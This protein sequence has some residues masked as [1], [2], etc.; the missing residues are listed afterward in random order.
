[1][2]KIYVKQ[3]SL[4]QETRYLWANVVVGLV[5]SVLLLRAWYVQIYRGETYQEISERNRIRRIEIPVPRGI[6]YDRHGEVI[7]GNRP[8]FDL[9]YIPQYVKDRESTFQILSRLLHVPVTQFERRYRM[10]RGNPKFLPINLKRN[11]EQHEVSTI[12]NHKLFLPGI[13]IKVSPRRDYKPNSPV[14]LL[15]YL[16][17][18]DNDA[19]REYNKEDSANP[20]LPGDLIGQ[21]GLEKVWESYLR[22]RRGYRLIQVDAY[23]RQASGTEGTKWNFPVV[24]AIRGSDLELTIDARLQNVVQQA[25]NGKFGA[26]I[27]VNP[28]TGEVLAEVSEPNFDPE[29]MQGG[30]T[31]EEWQSLISH[32]FKPFLDKTTGGEF[33][34]GSIYKPII[35]MA[36]LEEGIIDPSKTV[37]C[38]GHFFLG[39][40]PFYCHQRSGHGWVDLRKALMKSCDVYFYQIGMELGVNKIA[41]YARAFGLGEK[42]GVRLNSESSG[43]VPDSAW[44]QVTKRFPWTTGDTLNISIGQGDNLLTPM[45]MVSLYA[46]IANGGNVWR[47]YFVKRIT[48][49]IGEVQV[50]HHPE[51]VRKADIIKPE[52]YALIRRILQDVVMDEDG[53]GHKAHVEGFTVG[54]KTG[55]VQVVS[56]KKN[57]NQSDV[58]SKWREHAIF[59]AFSPVEKAEIA[60]VVLSQND[61]V[62]GGGRTAAPIAKKIIESYWK[63]K[64]QRRNVVALEQGE[65]GQSSQE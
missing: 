42:L 23:G 18:I 43:L 2:K 20:Y 44:K 63:F 55:S 41:K 65:D 8:F 48:N 21:Q 27:V 46:S 52:T 5:C 9:V 58:S 15:G 22:G 50:E 29:S 24:P 49:H 16:G 45:Q 3:N 17:E 62:G 59:A 11:L 12:E 39:K 60:V 37:Y 38:P 6:I 19:L 57:R 4:L 61:K 47:P 53:T 32:P 28:Q 10:S 25:F 64:D 56:L 35:A 26:V 51:L 54:G 36:A 7:L 31:S 34:P 1:V 33:A 14:H 13:D 30:L 40:E